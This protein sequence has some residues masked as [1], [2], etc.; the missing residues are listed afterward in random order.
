MTLL[1][2]LEKCPAGKQPKS[3]QSD[4]ELCP[5]GTYQP[6][7]GEAQC[8]R[9]SDEKSTKK[10]GALKESDCESE[11]CNVMSNVCLSLLLTP[12]PSVKVSVV[13]PSFHLNL[14]C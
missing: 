12:R 7:A 10:E 11:C 13:I 14:D 5:R 9:C 2:L 8:I 6:V 1:C 3:D 4:C